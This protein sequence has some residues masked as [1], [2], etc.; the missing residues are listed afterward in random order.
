[1][2]RRG[3]RVILLLFSSR[4]ITSR[5]PGSH[6]ILDF[7]KTPSNSRNMHV[8]CRLQ[9]LPRSQKRALPASPRE[10]TWSYGFAS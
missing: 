6:R 3:N 2:W 4:G 7:L 9:H 8:R 1:M 10:T 5:I